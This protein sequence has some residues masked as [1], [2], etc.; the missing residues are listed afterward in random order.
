MNRLARE[1]SPYLLQHADNPVDWYPWSVEAFETARKLDRP[2][3]VV[4]V[5][6]REN[7]ATK[8]ALR[9]LQSIYNPGTVLL[10]KNIPPG[11]PDLSAI[12]PWTAAQVALDE[13]PTYYVCQNF[14]RKLPTTD[15]A[16]ARE[17]LIE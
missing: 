4:V 1:Q 7:P 2:K 3:E 15:L 13:K 12:A 10:F 8:Q 16:E 9:E 11:A 5:G 6:P 14:T 17:L